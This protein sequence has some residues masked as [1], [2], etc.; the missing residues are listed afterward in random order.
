MGLENKDFLRKEL[1]TCKT[2]MDRFSYLIK[3]ANSYEELSAEQHLDK[4][5]VKGCNSQLWLVPELRDEK[6]YFLVDSDAAIPK[7]IA[8]I[9]AEVYSGLSCQEI[10]ELEP[11]L[12]EELGIQEH[13]SMSR[14]NGLSQLYKQV[15]LYAQAFLVMSSE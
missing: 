15:Y 11:T 4:F 2:P 7:G 10:L 3:K 13:L 1:S 6:L 14:R 5:K 8:V 12:F 9:L